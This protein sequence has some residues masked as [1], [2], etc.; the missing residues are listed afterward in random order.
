M[1]V[2]S[3]AFTLVTGIEINHVEHL[4]PARKESMLSKSPAVMA[5]APDME[6]GGA[7]V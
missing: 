4:R 5:L 7:H 1:L 6:K 2:E 3:G